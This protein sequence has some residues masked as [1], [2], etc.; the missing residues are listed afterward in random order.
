MA[1]RGYLGKIDLHNIRGVLQRILN[2]NVVNFDIEK[3]YNVAQLFLCDNCIDI[4]YK[5]AEKVRRVIQG[6]S[7]LFPIATNKHNIWKFHKTGLMLRSKAKRAGESLCMYHKGEELSYRNNS[8][9]MNIIGRS[10][11]ELAKRTLRVEYH[12]QTLDKIRKA[13]NIDLTEKR[14]VLLRGV[15]ESQ[16][17]PIIEMFKK[18]G[19]EP[20]YLKE[21]IAGW[22]DE[23]PKF[24]TNIS[25][26]LLCKIMI[27]ERFVEILIENGYD[28]E[29]TRNHFNVE[30]S[31]R[32][33]DKEL[34][35]FNE[36][37]KYRDR[38]LSFLVYKKPKS[39]TLLIELLEQIY[40]YYNLEA[41]GGS[42]NE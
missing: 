33:S 38:I 7:S 13:F 42:G 37:A 17:T 9:Y 18:F 15:L 30:Y 27:S 21:K 31:R 34:T 16:A 23:E 36:Y 29:R 20:R 11:Q 12:L 2:L 10:G 40:K 19:A 28:I 22:I 3:L 4:G 24:N 39:I 35:K 26:E 14:V 32:V 41:V 6:V 5:N 1:S 25:D 8:R